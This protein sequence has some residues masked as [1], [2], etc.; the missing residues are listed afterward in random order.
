M[1][2]LVVTIKPTIHTTRLLMTCGDDEVCK[3]V[4]PPPSTAHRYAAPTLLEGLSLWFG[5]RISVVLCAAVEDSACVL[6]LSDRLGCGSTT[7]HYDVEVVEPGRRQRGQRIA[8]VGAFGDLRQLSLR[9][10][11]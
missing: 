6:N 11:R 8:G 7:V 3:A 10:V 9:S 1:D 4:L 5:R 2:K